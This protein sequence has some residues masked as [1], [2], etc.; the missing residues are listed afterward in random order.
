MVYTGA[1]ETYPGIPYS[2]VVKTLPYYEK[3]DLGSNPCSRSGRE[4][5]YPR[6]CSETGELIQRSLCNQVDILFLLQKLEK[7]RQDSLLHMK[8]KG[9]E[10]T[11]PR[12]RTWH[13]TGNKREHNKAYSWHLRSYEKRPALVQISLQHVQLSAASSSFYSFS[14]SLW[15]PVCQGKTLVFGLYKDQHDT[16][17]RTPFFSAL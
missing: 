15:S 16:L 9:K 3:G 14:F 10:R 2:P 1:T 5:V 11:G 13:F 7:P 8:V 4:E 17:I 6:H 12:G